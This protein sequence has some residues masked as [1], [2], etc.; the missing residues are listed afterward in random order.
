M[1][2][3]MK[4]TAACMVKM[5]TS[6]EVAAA[7]H[8]SQATVSRVFSGQTNIRE[9]TRNRVLEAAKQLGYRPNALARGLTSSRSNLIAVVSLDIVNPHHNALIN[10]VTTR[11]QE[12]GSQTFFFVS[13]MEQKLDQILSQTLQYQV[14][15][16][17]VLA[18]ALSAQMTQECRKARVPVVVFNK[19][20]INE[21]IFSICSDN[22]GAGWMVANYLYDK[23]YRKFG[24]IGSDMIYGTSS[25]RQKGFTD[26]LAEKG[27]PHCRVEKGSYTYEGGWQAMK[28]MLESGEKPEAVFCMGDLMALGAMDCIRREFGLRIPEDIAVIGFDN[29]DPASWQSYELTT[30]TQE[31]DAMLDVTFDYL[32]KKLSGEPV[33]E[34][35]K[36]FPCRSLERSST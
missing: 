13:P 32:G 36:L 31:I 18:A 22:I 2:N 23:G 21:S 30:V 33:N 12:L 25:D 16:I 1:G 27:I 34:G 11:I 8:V 35:L 3:E 29:I 28:A 10:K 20:T 14:D 19:Y 24:Y 15:A 7:A 6:K 4:K 26:C 17:I 9:E 5:P